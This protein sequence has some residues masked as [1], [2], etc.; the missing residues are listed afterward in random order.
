MRLTRWC[1]PGSGTRRSFT[2]I[3][4]SRSPNSNRGRRTRWHS[5]EESSLD[6]WLDKYPLY[7]RP[8]FSISYYNK[9]Q[10]LGVALDILIR[11]PTDNRASL[12]DVCGA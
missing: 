6:A 5:A 7:N 4:A 9:G 12:D 1:A 3:L 11:D 8:E 2:P 10:L